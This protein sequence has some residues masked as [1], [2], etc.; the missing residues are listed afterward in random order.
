MTEPQGN[1]PDDQHMPP[2]I[3]ETGEL[4][5]PLWVKLMWLGGM[6]W[7]IWYIVSGMQSTPDK[8]A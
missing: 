5:I 6:A 2:Q 4:K 3:P 1:T 7:V 8:W